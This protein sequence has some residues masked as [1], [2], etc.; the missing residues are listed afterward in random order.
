MFSGPFVSPSLLRSLFRLGWLLVLIPGFAACFGEP[1]QLG[2]Q[3]QPIIGGKPDI[4]NPEIGA[5]TANKRTFCTGTLIA[6]RV[7]LTAG[8]CIDAANR[9][10]RSG[11]LLEFRIDMP[12]TKNPNGFEAKHFPFDTKLFSTHPKWNNNLS[13]GYDVG[14]GILK[15]KVTIVRPLPVNLSPLPPTMTGKKVLFLGYGLIKSNPTSVSPNRKY[16]AEIP[17]VKVTK[18]RFTV[19]EKGVSVCHGDSGGPSLTL[20]NGRTVTIG[21]NSY[22]SA[23]R[24]P[25]TTRSTC[26]GSGTAMRTDFVVNYIKTWLDKYG[27]GPDTCKTSTD[28]GLCASCGS[29]KVC[30]PVAF[31]KN[32]SICG[33][34]S[35]DADCKGGICHRFSTGYRCLYPCNN[36]GCCPNGTY[37]TSVQT[38]RSY[39]KL[40]LPFEGQCPDLKCSENKDCGPGEFC[41]N[42]FCLPSPVKKTETLCKACSTDK[43]CKGGLCT[44]TDNGRFCAQNCSAGDFCPPGYTCRELYAGMPR[45]CVPSTGVCSRTCL[46]S[47]HC[48]KG[49]ICDKGVCSTGKGAAAGESCDVLSCQSGLTCV[50]TIQGKRC[51]KSCGIPIRKPGSSCAGSS[52]DSPARCVQITTS[53]SYCFHTCRSNSDC[54]ANGGGYCNQGICLCNNDGQCSNNYLCNGNS[55]VAGACAKRDDYTPCS[56]GETCSL[57]GGLRYCTTSSTK[58]RGLGQSCDAI[59]GCREGYVCLKTPQGSVCFEECTKTRLCSLGGNCTP[60]GAGRSACMCG[61]NNQCPKGRSCLVYGRNFGLCKPPGF[62]NQCVQHKECPETHFCDKGSCKVGKRPEPTPE[63]APE[64]ITEPV[65]DASEPTPE[66]KPEPVAELSPEPA[67]GGN[68]DSGSTT[69]LKIVPETKEGCQCSTSQEHPASLWLL[70]G[71]IALGVRRRRC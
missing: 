41:E 63:P 21:V 51:L 25:G 55:G 11:Q 66:P 35:S 5:L 4:R 7:V 34:C 30:E 15:N 70:L 20:L 49:E 60:Y 50:Q 22:V 1:V 16:G 52:C 23:A 6:R 47:S 61:Q 17:I 54:S 44:T 24:V 27:D 45:Q 38:R 28:C 9:Y 12:S 31:P 29:K 13:N 14:V 58:T 65:P 36:N 2:Q 62:N 68:K 46:Y 8:H 59:H 3:Q 42:G 18:D 69:D 71:L 33:P 32:D 10:L 19:Y 53:S 39:S 40:C 67:D 56:K 48:S 26:E 43:D 64:S 57:F 37:C